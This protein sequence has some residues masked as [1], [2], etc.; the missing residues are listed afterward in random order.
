MEN[1]NKPFK[2]KVIFIGCSLFLLSISLLM[3]EIVFTRVSKVSFGNDFQFILISSAILGIGL[4]GIL[5]YFFYDLIISRNNY[6]KLLKILVAIYSFLLL[7][8][9]LV[10]HYLINYQFKAQILF[11]SLTLL[12]YIVWGACVSIIFTVYSRKAPFMYFS[13]MLGSGLGAF[14]VIFFL[15]IFG[16]GKTVIAIFIISLLSLI[17]VFYQKDNVKN[18]IFLSGSFALCVIIFYN[19]ITPQLS[20][21]C[22][23]QKKPISSET[24]SFSQI[25]TYR[26][27]GNLRYFDEDFDKLPKDLNIYELKIDCIGI[28]TFIEYKPEMKFIEE[29]VKFLPFVAKNHTSSLIIGSGAGLEVLMAV[30]AGNDKVTGVEINP[31]IIKRVR[32][33]TKNNSSLNIYNHPSVELAVDEAR[34]FVIKSTDKYDL[35]YIPNTKRYGGSGLTSYAFLENYLYTQEA[36]KLYLSHLNDDGFIAVADINWYVLRYLKNWVIAME[37]E[38]ILFNNNVIFIEGVEKSLAIFKKTP[39]TQEEI[40]RINDHAQKIGLNVI[41]AKPENLGKLKSNAISITDDRPY[42]WNVNSIYDKNFDEI[43]D[44]KITYRNLEFNSIKHLFILFVIISIVLIASFSSALLRRKELD[45]NI[46]RYLFYFFF[47]GT[48]FITI[49]LMLIHKFTI[50]VENPVYALSVILSSILVFSSIGS[51]Y[52]SRIQKKNESVIYYAAAALVIV[53]II[54][55]LSLTYLFSKLSYL[56]LFFKILLSIVLISI[57]SFFMGIF[58]PV[59]LQKVAQISNKSVPWMWGINGIAST[60]G[61]VLSMIISLL[62]GFNAALL[63]GVLC[64]IF[65]ALALK[66]HSQ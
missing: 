6:N 7:L 33:I 9:F 57:P 29:S 35:I 52:V 58:F 48:G 54:Y 61:G 23:G 14:L 49:E 44:K 1:P 51:Y 64:Y 53:L 10:L 65:A 46:S 38:G 50:F 18:L 41:I 47:I 21:T 45:S 24:N 26:F 32:Q 66:G 15:D 62:F 3:L 16:V 31:L 8:P 22:Q 25:D 11:F 63:I 60:F 37:K 17:F 55:I 34:N 36:F 28:T 20:I 59:G 56:S 27:Q 13:S 5:V 12:V 30:H 39:F 42:Y 19:F 43:S 2:T 40:A 4:G